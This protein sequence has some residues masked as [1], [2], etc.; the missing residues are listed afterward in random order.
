MILNF[1]SPLLYH[2]S[3]WRCI[4]SKI[5]CNK[6]ILQNSIAKRIPCWTTHTYLSTVQAWE[7]MAWKQLRM[8]RNEFEFGQQGL[9]I[10][11]SLEDGFSCSCTICCKRRWWNM[12][13]YLSLHSL[14]PPKGNTLA[15]I[16][17]GTWEKSSQAAF[18]KAIFCRQFFSNSSLWNVVLIVAAH[19]LSCSAVKYMI[20]CFVA[21]CVRT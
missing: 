11:W 18:S 15:C 14:V 4:F 10:W 12:M 17:M 19:L 2:F 1:I 7:K 8:V 9:P 5:S 16:N 13:T 21:Q 3:D 20:N 6:T